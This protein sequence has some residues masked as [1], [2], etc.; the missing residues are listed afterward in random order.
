MFRSGFFASCCSR[1]VAPIQPRRGYMEAISES[2][3]IV[4]KIVCF[5]RKLHDFEALDF[6]E[7]LRWNLGQHLSDCGVE[8]PV[9]V[10]RVVGRDVHDR[11]KSIH[12][13]GGLWRPR[14][15]HLEDVD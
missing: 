10:E 15:R 3:E 9:V 6:V 7:K 12:F 2:S 11:L 13:L 8:S 1:L 5:V 4:L 14:E